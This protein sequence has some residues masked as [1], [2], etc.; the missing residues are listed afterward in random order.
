MLL[1][2]SKAEGQSKD[3]FSWAY[4]W[5]VS[6]LSRVHRW[7]SSESALWNQSIHIGKGPILSTEAGG[8]ARS[9]QK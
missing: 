2:G 6:V 9:N 1:S 4:A 7:F 5:E 3:F 8:V